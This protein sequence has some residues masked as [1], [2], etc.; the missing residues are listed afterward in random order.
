MGSLMVFVLK[1]I[2]L[3]SLCLFDYQLVRQC[4]AGSDS[5]T[6]TYVSRSRWWHGTAS[7]SFCSSLVSFFH[8][9]PLTVCLMRRSRSAIVSDSSCLKSAR[10]RVSEMPKW[11]WLFESS[12][13]NVSHTWSTFLWSSTVSSRVSQQ[14][15]APSPLA[16]SMRAHC[17]SSGTWSATK[18]TFIHRLKELPCG[19]LV[20]CSP[21]HLWILLPLEPIGMIE[22]K[23]DGPFRTIPEGN[24]MRAILCDM[25][26][27]SNLTFGMHWGMLRQCP[28]VMAYRGRTDR[29][30]IIKVTMC[31]PERTK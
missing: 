12:S 30:W 13:R 27:D 7:R 11:S 2:T 26:E 24:W 9:H 21:V 19:H 29:D 15:Y 3:V 22:L 28:L 16:T 25:V 1:N 20:G 10:V 17:L 14:L 8:W 31:C 23:I 6:C 18:I 4:M 5:C